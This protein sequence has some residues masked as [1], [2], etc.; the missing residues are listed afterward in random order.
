[1]EIHLDSRLNRRNLREHNVIYLSYMQTNIIQDTPLSDIAQDRFGR[2][3][4]VD[5]IVGS[6]NQVVSSDHP[7]TVYGIYG[8]WGEG[9]TSLMNFIKSK[10]L[11]QRKTDGI[12]IVEFNPWLVNNDEALLQEFFKT[13]MSNP[14]D[15]VRVAFKKYGSLA[16]FA[17]K[18]IVNTFAPGLGS[19]LAKGIKWAQKA[20]DDSKSSLAE[21]KKKASEA[22]IK[23]RRHLVIMIDDVDR[24]DKEEL[25]AML[26]LVRQVADFENCIYIIAMDVDMV[27]K[28][29][30][31]YHGGGLHQDGR[32]FIDKI[33]QVPITLP[34]VSLSDMQKLIRKEL[35][36]TLQDSA[37]EEQIEGISKAVFPF[38]TT[39]RELKRY[40]NQLSFVLPYMIGEVN[41]Q[42]LC[43]LEAIKMVNAES[44]SRIYE[45]EDALRHVV[46]PLSILSKDK[47]IEEAAN[48]YETAKEY[49]TEGIT[50]R[51][52][53]TINDTL[54]TLFNDSS[55]LAQDDIDNKKLDT[56]VYFQ[57][58]FTQLVP[59]NL[60]PDRELDAFKAVFKE[61]SV[62]KMTDCFDNWLEKYSASEVKRAALYVIRRCPYGD[63]RCY[64]ASVIAKALSVSKLAKGLPSHVFTNN[65]IS[66][67]V[68]VQVIHNNMFVQNEEYAQWSVW[69]E[70]ILDDT[71]SYIFE[72][73]EMNYCMNLLCSCDNVLS[74]GIYDGR[75][76]LP[77]LI[78]RFVELGFEEQIKYSKF[79]L[80][81]LLKQWKRVDVDGYNEYA[82]N[83]FMNPQIPFSKVMEKFI[84]GT[85]DGKDVEI[86]VNLFMLQIPQINDRLSKENHEVR[87]SH[88]VKIYAANYKVLMAR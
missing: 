62:E 38:I 81:T 67:F 74:S 18:T 65:D 77:V 75:R 30:A 42:D 22:I 35:S 49:I 80:I 43:T 34:Q 44:Y 58:Y 56:D 10:L 48:N 12:S 6:I 3:S 50:G 57:K 11:A 24:L 76:S 86:F 40:C 66:S 85:D 79:L 26:R 15:A 61:L 54:D 9:K 69:N 72:K 82:K 70:D 39:C 53:D 20:L 88:A 1:M 27:S 51:L 83:L 31:D 63:E 33:V 45:Q 29:I 68:A 64:A 47:G 28:S 71:L 14:D 4:I 41:I 78:K 16:I 84:D 19:S 17:S 7:C 37:N 2:E 60:I 25:H 23:S 55:V 46:G 73:A 8:K 59:G 5:L 21:L 52:K 32:K 36:S 87:E 13:V